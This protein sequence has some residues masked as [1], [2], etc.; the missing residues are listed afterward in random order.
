MTTTETPAAEAPPA[1]AA[2]SLIG[3][4]VPRVQDER[5]LRGKGRYADDVSEAGVLHAAVVRSPIAAGQVTA[6]DTTQAEALEGVVL[7][8][9]PDEIAALT[10]PVAS[11]WL[12]WGQQLTHV[13][14]VDRAIRYVGQPIAVVVASSRALAED[15]LE[16]IDVEYDDRPAVIGLDAAR[17]EDAALV[18]PSLGSNQVGSFQFGPPQELLE[19]VFAGAAHVV[20]RTFTVPRISHSPLEPR[21]LVAEWVEATQQLSVHSS[22]QVPHAVRQELACVLRLRQDQVRVVAADV[23]G[24]F[25]QKTSLFPD[26]AMVCLAAM[27]LGRT[28]KWIEDRVEALTAS[29]QG[30]GQVTRARLGLDADGRFLVIHAD[31]HGDVGAFTSTTTGGTGPFQVAG[32]MLEG[33]YR[34][35]IAAS[36]VTAWYTNAVPTGAFRG[37]GMQEATFIRERLVDEAARELGT[38]PVE[39]RRRNMIQP[40]QLPHVTNTQV[41]YDNGDYPRVLDRA[42]ALA[43]A[44]A[45]PSKDRVRRG[46]GYSSMVEITGFA[47]SALLELYHIHWSGYETS[48]IRVN[49]DGTVTVFSGA[50]SIGQGIETSLAQVAAERLGVPLEWVRVQLG[51]TL[52]SPY[53]NMGS[54]ASRGLALAGGALWKA[55]ATLRERMHALA[56]AYLEASPEDVTFSEG[57]FRSA[58]GTTIAWREVAHRGWMGWRRRAD[59]VIRLEETVEYDPASITFG[60]ATHAAQV[61]VDLDT[62]KVDIE[63]YWV[64]HDSGVVV[65]PLVGDGQIIG[66]VAMGIGAALLEESTFSPDGQPTATTYLDYIVPISE[67]VPDLVLDHIVTPSE[68]TPGGFKGIGE[69]GTIPPPAAIANAVAAAVPEIAAQ[70]VAIPLSPTRVWSMLDAAGLTR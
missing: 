47:P 54:Q 2:E 58:A 42:V 15:A 62:G 29:Y 16:L 25:G 19:D 22:T 27:R 50:T 67:D 60:Y 8:L 1:T 40:D 36:T 65:N 31:M 41:P 9:G 14:I 21:G 69:S 34:F 53:S 61:A 12:L 30:R 45:R 64:V 10:D 13:P 63:D 28:V 57:E 20:D 17:A 55:A 49:E 24:A 68:L 6:F 37:Y 5:L 4:R 51:D 32:L 66:G 11:S 7:V 46:I 33:P 52:T 43:S 3:A 56:S 38:D 18:Y 35:D 59:D 26:E 39:L 70:V 44:G 23:G 48:T